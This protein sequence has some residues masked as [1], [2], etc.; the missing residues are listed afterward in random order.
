MFCSEPRNWEVPCESNQAHSR[1]AATLSPE[2]DWH[3][4]LA[5]IS[6][7]TRN[8]TDPTSPSVSLI[9][10][11]NSVVLCFEL[12]QLCPHIRSRINS[13]PELYVLVA[14]LDSLTPVTETSYLGIARH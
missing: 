12:E 13:T 5:E 4:T 14:F 7:P 9:P 1:P 8:S 10:S 3:R 6:V 2:L 11:G